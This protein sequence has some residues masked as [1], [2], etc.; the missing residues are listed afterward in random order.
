MNKALQVSCLKGLPVRVVRSFKEKRSSYAP[1]Q[2]RWGQGG[3]LG[4][5]GACCE[6]LCPGPH[7]RC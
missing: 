6:A 2:V 5:R 3:P 7:S 1:S 4:V